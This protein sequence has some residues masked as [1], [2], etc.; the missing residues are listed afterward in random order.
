MAENGD[1]DDD[2]KEEDTQVGGSDI[3]IFLV[4][5]MFFLG[6]V[7]SWLTA[8][9]IQLFVLICCELQWLQVPLFFVLQKKRSLIWCQGA[10]W[11]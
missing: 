10:S 2:D 5:N 3:Q 9:V 4:A 8:R 11:P 6:T 1:D 7:N